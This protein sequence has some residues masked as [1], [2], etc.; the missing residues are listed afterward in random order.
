MSFRDRLSFA[1]FSMFCFP[2]FVLLS[3]LLRSRESFRSYATGCYP[4]TAR[5]MTQRANFDQQK[6]E[7]ADVQAKAV[8]LKASIL[9]YE[10][11]LALVAPEEVA[12]TPTEMLSETEALTL[13]GGQVA[14]TSSL[15]AEEH[16]KGGLPNISLASEDASLEKASSQNR[17]LKSGGQL[18]FVFTQ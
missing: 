18:F 15:G 16:L 8:Q 17:I 9:Y 1:F 3:Y 13:N 7:L 14:S 10:G 6:S 12:S 4:R 11:M 2:K 5:Q